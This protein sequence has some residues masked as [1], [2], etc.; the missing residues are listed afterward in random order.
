MCALGMFSFFRISSGS[1][2]TPPHQPSLQ[3]CLNLRVRMCA[4]ITCRIFGAPL[5]PHVSVSRSP[6][7]THVCLS[8]PGQEQESAASPFARTPSL[9]SPRAKH[10]EREQVSLSSLSL[11]PLFSLSVLVRACVLMSFPRPL[12]MPCTVPS[13]HG[14]THVPGYP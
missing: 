2:S 4:P 6:S 3:L 14:R 13:S 5:P 7:H 12:H 1:K 9:N 10:T 8:L 11:L